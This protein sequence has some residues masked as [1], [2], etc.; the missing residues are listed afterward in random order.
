M[1]ANGSI[2]SRILSVLVALCYVALAAASSVHEVLHTHDVGHTHEG[3][4]SISI[5]PSSAT[6]VLAESGDQNLAGNLTLPC[7]L[8]LTGSHH[9]IVV[10]SLTLTG[11]LEAEAIQPVLYEGEV[12]KAQYQLP[13]LRAPPLS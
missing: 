3:T 13:S 6:S 4:S 9:S 11:I 7:F 12:R 10:D 8:C 2:S 1:L 5:H